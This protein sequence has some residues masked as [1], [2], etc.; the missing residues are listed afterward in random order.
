MRVV[1]IRHGEA[2][3]PRSSPDG[4]RYLTAHGRALSREVARALSRRGIAPTVIYTSPLVR[5]VQTAEIVAHELG[6]ADAIL[7]HDQLVPG[8]P[9]GP[10]LSVLDHHEATEIVALVSH[11]PTL[12]ALAGHLSGHGA[13]FPGFRTSGAAV[14]DVDEDGAGTLVGR[15]DPSTLQWR[16]AD[17]LGP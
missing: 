11:E 1:L 6:H 4:S 5:A 15:L 3:D 10:A 12:S 16:D 2:S 14:I 7:V 17:D 9:T 13:M 8:A